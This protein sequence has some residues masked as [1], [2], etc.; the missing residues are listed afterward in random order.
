[1]GRWADM[2]HAYLT[3]DTPFM[4]SV[5]WVFKSIYDKGLVYE[6]YRVMHICPRCETTL[7]QAEVAEGYK[8]VKDIAVTVKFK[9]K[10]PEKLGLS[11]DAYLLAWTTTPWTLPGNVA[12]A[13]GKD[14]TYAAYRMPEHDGLYIVA[15]SKGGEAPEGH[16]WKGSDLVGLEY[17]P[18][19]DYYV[20]DEK[21][22]NR[23]NGWKVYAADF[24]TDEEGTGIAH[25]APAFG[26]DDWELLKKVD[27]PFVQ[28]VNFDGTMKQ[29]VRDFAGTEVKPRSDDDAVRL[30]TD[31]AVLKNLQERG[32][33]FSKETVTH[34]Y[35]H[36]WRCDS[37]LLNYA[38]SSL[39]VNVTRL[40]PE[41]LSHAKRIEWFPA[42]IKEGRF[43]KWLEGARDWSISRQRFWASVIPLWKCESCKE[44]R[45]FGS[46]AELEEASGKKV[47][48]LHKH[49]VD[50]ITVPCSC[51]GVMHRTPD[52]LDT[53]F[54]SGSMP[55]GEKHYPFE[56]KERFDDSFPAA[57]I[58]EGID[59]T[60]TWF[61]YLHVLSGA[62]FGKNAF[63]H[64]V[65][66]GTVLAEDGKKMSKKLQNYPDPMA[67]V[68]KYGADALRYYLLSSPVVAAENLAF[69][70]SGVDEAAKKHIGRL[71]NV[72]AFYKL[73]DDGTE[74]D[75]TS[76]NVLDRW[77]LARLAET[78]R[79][80]TAAYDSYDLNAATRPLAPFI[81]DL[82][83]WYVRRS[84]D[85]F[86]EEGTDKQD[87]LATLRFAL[88]RLARL[89]APAMPFVAEELFQ[90]VRAED[91]PESVHL[92]EWPAEAR[93]LLDR[94][95][96]AKEDAL[97][98][99]MQR[100]RAVASEALQMRQKAGIKVRQPLAS[101][102][103]TDDLSKE[104]LGIL[105][106]EVNVEA[107]A[108]GAALSLDTNLTPD[109]VR[110]G[111]ERELARAVADARKQEGLSPKDTAHIEERAE[112][113]YE[114]QLSS[115]AKRFDLVKDAA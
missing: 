68:E 103:V 6:D 56:E 107:V 105:A 115:G 14:I 94:M 98:A 86:K 114:A 26:A 111:D 91:D 110:K 35:P 93:G 20:H 7:S 109:L 39:F 77:M 4:E 22:K 58:A 46:V 87:A 49:V 32:L 85:R 102:T 18:P 81:D 75:D 80:I 63:R 97:I 15:E 108:K 48:D 113:K 66:N 104:L 16:S 23:A 25:E 5:W 84:R 64:V 61:Y 95:F 19:F 1:I 24:V 45:V 37:P 89:M 62:L 10:A 82:S 17:E 59:Q 55:Y 99:E 40:K 41:L 78:T 27:L 28:H 30:G 106:D 100:V 92:A 72:L 52:V 70:E 112:G 12:L 96:G 38:T 33:L 54:D 69:F 83:A 76:K 50:E 79:A 90:G 9:L 53:W 71:L 29:E 60:R 67:I 101:L 51:G 11:G 73:F 2:E 47:T 34:S 74:A 43:G 31:I 3:M 44:S 21:L 42:H 36:C 88:A 13:V 8:D 65:V 57:F